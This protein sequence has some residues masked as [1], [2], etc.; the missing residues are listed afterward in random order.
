M[1]VDCER[2]VSDVACAT[3]SVDDYSRGRGRAVDELEAGGDR[4]R[5]EEPLATAKQ[6]R[7]GPQAVLIDQ[8][9]L[10]QGLQESAAAVD[11]DLPAPRVLERGHGL[12]TSP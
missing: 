6:D 5:V 10:D 2:A 8:V 11:L 12:G 9:V 1:L 7:E 4:S 3:V